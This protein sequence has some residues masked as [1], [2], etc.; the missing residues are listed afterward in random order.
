M[1]LAASPLQQ[2]VTD[3]RDIIVELNRCFTLRTVGPGPDDG[4]LLGQSE[5]TNIQKATHD[6]SE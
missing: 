2:H 6:R 3:Q 5:D 4:F 1:A